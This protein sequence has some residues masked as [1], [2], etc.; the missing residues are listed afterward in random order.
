MSVAVEYAASLLS[1]LITRVVYVTL[2]NLSA[3]VFHLAQISESKVE[4]P[5]SMIPATTQ[6]LSP[7]LKT[8]P[9]SRLGFM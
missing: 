9:T 8:S 7:M 4:P 3:T 5:E 6:Y 2:P 1:V